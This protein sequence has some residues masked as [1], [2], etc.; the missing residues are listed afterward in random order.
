MSDVIEILTPATPETVEVVVTGPQGPQG[1]PGDEVELQKTSTHVQWRYVGGSWTNLVL[2]SD[3][4]GP[5]GATGATGPQGIAGTGS[6][7]QVQASN[8]TAAVGLRY[9]T[10]GTV[11]VADP[12]SATAGQGYELVVG[13]GA[14]TMGGVTYG[15]SRFMLVRYFNGTTWST[16]ANSITETLTV[17]SLAT[18]APVAW[19]LDSVQTAAAAGGTLTLPNNANVLRI[20]ATTTISAIANGRLGAFYF[21]INESGGNLQLTHSANLTVRGAANLTL[22]TNQTCTILCRTATTASV[23]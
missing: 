7:L 5:T 10:N 8:F 12:S 21:V 9:L 17:G 13:S 4:T 15:P 23:H 14:T 11:T 6:T 19:A 16:L 20:T 3:I 18:A 22:G 1:A 2:L